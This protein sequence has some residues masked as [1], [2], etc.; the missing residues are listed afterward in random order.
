MLSHHVDIAGIFPIAPD[1]QIADGMKEHE[2]LIVPLTATCCIKDRM[3]FVM[4]CSLEAT[5]T[6][7]A[8]ADPADRT[9]HRNEEPFRT[10]L[11]ALYQ[12]IGM[13]VDESTA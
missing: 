1:A 8:G 4:E 3:G 5:D 12:D 13:P 7:L 2:M 11:K 9:S 10:R 6:M